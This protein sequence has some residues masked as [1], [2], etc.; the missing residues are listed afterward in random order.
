[1]KHTEIEAI[2][3]A[4]VNEFI[5]KGYTI[6]ATTMSGSQGEIA[7]ID[8]RKATKFTGSCWSRPPSTTTTAPATSRS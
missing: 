1:M 3:T 7:K 6:N 8:F 4:K 2:M 5:T